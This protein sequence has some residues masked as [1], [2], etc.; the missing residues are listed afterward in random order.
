MSA[1]RGYAQGTAV[2]VSKSQAE[3]HKLL[4]RAGA[5]SAGIL[6]NG[7]EGS[8]AV[9]FSLNGARYKV[10]IP[11]P[12]IKELNIAKAK[13]RALTLDQLHRERW[14]ALCLHLKS[15]LEIVRIGISTIEKEFLADLVLPS[16]E[17]MG[18]VIGI[19][20]Q[21]GLGATKIKQLGAGS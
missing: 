10:E 18:D 21:K 1:V 14:R 8:I 11:L 17:V 9:L 20:I 16:G 19:A 12:G 7:E 3:I 4:A 13:R 2:E 6:T 5:T 15:K